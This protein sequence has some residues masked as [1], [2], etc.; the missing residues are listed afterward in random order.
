MDSIRSIIGGIIALVAFGY[1]IYYLYLAFKQ[2]KGMRK[3]LVARAF[4]GFFVITI[5]AGMILPGPTEEEIAQQEAEEQAEQ[6]QKEEK[7]QE[8][9]REKEERK[10]VQQ[11]SEDESGESSEVTAAE[12]MKLGG[13]E[14]RIRTATKY[15]IEEYDLHRVKKLRL[16]EVVVYSSEVIRDQAG[17]EFPYSYLVKGRYEEKQTGALHDFYMTLVYKN[18]EKV[19][20]GEASCIQYLNPT[21]RTNINHMN[22]E[23]DIFKDLLSQ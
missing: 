7:K 2:E 14:A 1:L 18:A 17:N 23:D 21:K 8:K 11:E 12:L 13:F 9:E 20:K 15:F 19:R 4:V 16:E 10:Q 6:Q 22:S 5:V 3:G